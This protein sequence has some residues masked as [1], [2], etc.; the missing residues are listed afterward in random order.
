MY[1]AVVGPNR[2]GEQAERER[3]HQ[4]ASPGEVHV[5]LATKAPDD[6]SGTAEVEGQEDLESP[7]LE[8]VRDAVRVDDLGA[9]R[10][11]AREVLRIDRLDSKNHARV[12]RADEEVG[13]CL[14]FRGA[15]GPSDPLPAGYT[16]SLLSTGEAH[17]ALSAMVSHNVR[18][19][20]SIM[21]ASGRR[22]GDPMYEDL[23]QHGNLGLI[24]AVEKFNPSMGYKFSTYATWWIR[25]NISR[26]AI[27][28]GTTIRIPV[29]MW[30]DMEKVRKAER[31][32]R[33]ERMDPTVDDLAVA[34]D[35]RPEK[36][37]ECQILLR[38]TTVSFEHP[39][40]EGATL[41][42]LVADTMHPIPGP[43]QALWAAFER[44]DIIRL[45]EACEFKNRDRQI[46]LLRFGFFDGTPWTLEGIGR[47][48]GVTRERIRQIEKKALEALRIQVARNPKDGTSPQR[49]EEP[50]RTA[51][52]RLEETR[53]RRIRVSQ[54]RTAAGMSRPKEGGSMPDTERSSDEREKTVARGQDDT[55]ATSAVW[56][57]RPGHHDGGREFGNAAAFAFEADLEVLAREA[58][59][60][61]LDERIRQNH[62]P[63]RV[64]YTLH[65]LTGEPLSR[66]LEALR[67]KD[68]HP[69]YEAAA[70]QDQK[71][72][73]VIRAGLEEMFERGRLVL[74][75]VDDYN[76]NGLTGDDYE[77]GRFAAVVRRQLD[78][79]KS[80]AGAGGS[81]GLG[82]ATLWATSRIG[83][84]LMNSTLSE[85]HEGRTERRLIGR[86]DLPWREVNGS[87]YAGPAWLGRPDPEADSA[88]VARSWWAD[89]AEV[90][91]LHLTREGP[92]PGTSFLIVGA[93]DV[94]TLA[95]AGQDPEGDA[96]DDEDSLERMHQRL[97]RAIGRNF[98]A[99]MTTGGTRRPL[100]EASVRT[101]RN[102]TEYLPEERVDPR[103]HQPA[104]SRALQAFL[105]GNTVERLTEPGQ[106]ALVRVPLKIPHQDGRAGSLGE[107]QAVL[108]VTDATDADGR[109]NQVT[110]MRG[111][112]MTVKTTRVPNLPVGTNPFQAVLLAGRAAGDGSP[113]SAEA[114]EF[115]RC[116]EP[117]EHN[118]WG[119]TEELRTRYSPSA[120]RRILALTTEANRAVHKLVAFSEGKKTSGPSKAKKRLKISGKPV[121][122][123][124]RTLTPP[125]LDDLEA[126]INS[127][128]AW[129]VTAEVKIPSGRDSWSMNPVAKL[130]VR[131][132]PRPVVAWAELVAV[133]N[134][135]L[136]DGVLRF[137]SG[138]RRAVFRG[139]TDVS[140]HPVR[141]ALTGLVVELH[142]NRGSIA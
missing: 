38:S 56:Y 20:H 3:D 22:Q 139:V 79:R 65:E 47:Q 12:L 112:R 16:A 137:T 82:K 94:A 115:L 114:E 37:E 69:H 53:H 142:E 123:A 98:W 30:T 74:L 68:L 57:H 103:V 60:N 120:H 2:P 111:N 130:E 34:C 67:W 14:L 49:S 133:S 105:S 122:K 80:D 43:E 25:Q 72:G 44:Q 128:G 129:Q 55:P 100:L 8:A 118:K 9:A 96:G 113:F 40:G 4:S 126:V 88:D 1:R 51:R 23:V 117:P 85:P 71:V 116:S 108:L 87:R 70:A 59:Q 18:L 26:A 97:V 7:E 89:E 75:R 127:S 19:V 83:L 110:A 58:T 33:A 77:D 106:V 41:G 39:I 84:V 119:Q 45:F 62:Q 86:L 124:R 10:R 17:E 92:D 138:A 91:N 109:I 93:H 61:S 32:F 13:L 78:S 140:T 27:N 50:E 121:A 95:A 136:T 52:N 107:H 11:A 125:T 29:H 66:F 76:A 141:A 104:R 46:L 54:K 35:L 48:F 21:R 42:D 15:I 63:V 31:K 24:R 135:D 132:G 134:C 64:R 73:R 81:Y 90:A 6:D 102:G 5:S 36:V 101:L 99:A 28:E 131:S